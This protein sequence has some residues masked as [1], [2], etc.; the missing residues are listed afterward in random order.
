MRV[1]RDAVG[2]G[3]VDGEEAADALVD[4]GGL[5]GVFLGGG[6]VVVEEEVVGDGGEREGVGGGLGG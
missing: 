4:A 2:A 1:Q 5:D 3:G 6:L